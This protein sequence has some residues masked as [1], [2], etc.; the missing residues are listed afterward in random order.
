MAD[1][2]N[3]IGCDSEVEYLRCPSCRKTRQKLPGIK[4]IWEFAAIELKG[5]KGE[6]QDWCCVLCKKGFKGRKGTKS[7]RYYDISVTR[8]DIK[9]C[10]VT[11]HT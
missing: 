2:S 10:I 8:S 6:G 3:A 11:V 4:S 5:D 9:A 7:E 1:E